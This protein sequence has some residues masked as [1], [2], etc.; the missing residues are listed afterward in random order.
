MKLIGLRLCEHDSNVSYYDGETVRYFKSERIYDEKH[1]GYSDLH[2]WKKDFKDIFGDDPEDADEIAI[3]IDPWVHNLPTDNEEFF[4][5]IKYPAVSNNC[6]RVN[7]HWA[8]ALSTFKENCL[9]VVID[10]FGDENNSWTVF[11]NNEVIYRG[12]CVTEGSLGCEMI[13]AGKLLNIKAQCDLDI[14]GKLMGLQS[15]GTYMKEYAKIL[16]K[17]MHDIRR[18]FEQS[19]YKAFERDMFGVLGQAP[20]NWI[21]TVHD[22]MGDVLVNFF[23]E[24][25]YHTLSLIHI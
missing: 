9:H 23:S 6:W 7:H 12:Y 8:H 21:R 25:A 24:Y 4:P 10:G 15:Y 5:A 16:P 14:A 17:T 22:H 11:R 1:H 3:V 20:L 18:I 2:S 19:R 13:K